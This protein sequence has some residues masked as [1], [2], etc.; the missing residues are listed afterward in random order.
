ME[1]DMEQAVAGVEQ[2]VADL[3]VAEREIVAQGAGRIVPS[4]LNGY[5]YVPGK[6]LKTADGDYFY[7]PGEGGEI[8]RLAFLPATGSLDGVQEFPSLDALN[9]HLAQRGPADRAAVMAFFALSEQSREASRMAGASREAQ[10]AAVEPVQQDAR[11]SEAQGRDV[12]EN[13][14]MPAPVDAGTALGERMAK[15]NW[16]YAYLQDAGERA[17]ARNIAESILK[18][19]AAFAKSDSKRAAELWTQHG[20]KTI[21][22]PA[23]VREAMGESASLDPVQPV[24]IAGAQVLD[25]AR[26]REAQEHA[27]DEQGTENAIQPAPG[28]L[29]RKDAHH[30]AEDAFVKAPDQA[31]TAEQAP[32]GGKEAAA[33]AK[34][35]PA[36][37]LAGRFV[38]GENGEYR[39]QGES[40]VALVDEAEKI[41]FVDKQ[42][43]AFQAAVELAKHKQWEAILVTG[44]DKFRA[45]AWY[46]A[47]LAGLK[48][49]GYEPSEKEQETLKAAL[50]R[51]AVKDNSAPER[52]SEAAGRAAAT[53]RS[54]KDANEFALKSTG[55]TQPLNVQAGRY[56]GKVLHETDH[57]VVQ[58][59]G[60]KVAVVHE[61]SR[62]N[63]REL[64]AAIERGGSI[65]VQ[66]DQGKGSI[67]AG[68]S[69]SQGRSR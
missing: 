41:R 46:H 11:G 52:Q 32:S 55:V 30:G 59:I 29:P 57:H 16:Y 63:A 2:I 42:M 64:K 39:R 27:A 10:A 56:V 7:T 6:E 50:E 33:T 28:T 69:R 40:R 26:R 22:P 38:R 58:D 20:P 61:K 49:V 62:F 68:K 24:G 66:Y 54:L 3:D 13:A 35:G 9:D 53:E 21:S 12:V 65:R 18:D 1:G 67:D 8:S 47:S 4:A 31:A 37:L 60:K 51:A 34:E 5:E 23:F 43:D 14:I 25:A 44:T 45:E 17:A 19:L 36:T 48:V 15:A